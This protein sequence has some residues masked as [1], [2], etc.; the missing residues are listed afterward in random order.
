[1]VY[2]QGQGIAPIVVQHKSGISATQETERAGICC[3]QLN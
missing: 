1:M 2:I 3:I